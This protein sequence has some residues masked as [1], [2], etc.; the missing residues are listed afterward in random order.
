MWERAMHVTRSTL[1]VDVQ[2]TV[3]LYGSHILVV[4]Q[5]FERCVTEASTSED[6][7]NQRKRFDFWR[8][9]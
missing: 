6:G 9:P 5:L 1:V 8:L 7:R 4:K 2:Y 3:C